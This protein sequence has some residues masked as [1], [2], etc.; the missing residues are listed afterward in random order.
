MEGIK[1]VVLNQET[2]E[3]RVTSL[4]L[5]PSRLEDFIGQKDLVENI[6]VSVGAARQR[7]EPLEHILFS[8]PP[9]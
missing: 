8:G 2:E 1:R 4:S 7:K 6:R 3:D 9:G 5:R